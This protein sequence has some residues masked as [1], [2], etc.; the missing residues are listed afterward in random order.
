MLSPLFSP[1]TGWVGIC[2][3]YP[4]LSQYK[5]GEGVRCLAPNLP[6]LGRI[7]CIDISL[8]DIPGFRRTF[9]VYVVPAQNGNNRY[10]LIV[11]SSL[12]LGA[13]NS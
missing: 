4:P 10:H 13:R 11:I 7:F 9:P 8:D 3:E 5:D 2:V 6:L 12:A 1:D